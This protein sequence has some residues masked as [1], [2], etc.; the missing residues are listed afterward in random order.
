MINNKNVL[1]ITGATVYYNRAVIKKKELSFRI[2][3]KE[4]DLEL[5]RGMIKD[6]HK[7]DSIKLTFENN[8]NNKK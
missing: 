8:N 2:N 1:V 6:G 3:V 5:M 4:E 7:A